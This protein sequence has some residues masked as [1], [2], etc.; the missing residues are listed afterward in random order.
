[1]RRVAAHCVITPSQSYQQAVV[2]LSDGAVVEIFTFTEELPATEWLGGTIYVEPDE[3]GILRA[4]QD[5]VQ[6]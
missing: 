6:L 3:N 2:V 1:M 4:Y 5:G